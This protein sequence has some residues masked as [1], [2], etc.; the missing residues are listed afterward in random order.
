MMTTAVEDLQQFLAERASGIGGSDV[1]S[2]FS[3]GY[4]C[5]RRLSYDKRQVP[6]DFPIW[7]N[8]PMELGK[9]LEPYVARKYEEITGR[10]VEI[11]GVLRHP[12][13]PELLVHVDRIVTA[14]ERTDPG[15]MEIKAVG[16][17]MFA[18]IK[19]EGIL[20]DYTLQLNHGMLVA[21]LKWGCFAVMN[22]D[23][24]IS[25]PEDLLRWDVERDDEICA[26]ILEEGPLFWRNLHQDLHEEAFDEE[27]LDPGDSRC[28]RCPWRLQCQGAALMES[29][30]DDEISEDESLRPLIDEYLERKALSDEA[31]DLLEEIK[32]VIRT[33]MG[34]RGA[35]LSAGAK[36]YFRPQTT[37]RWD[38]KELSAAYSRAT[39][40]VDYDGRFIPAP[41]GKI[42]ERF[43]KGSV[44]RPLRIYPPKER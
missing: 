40:T 30:S 22:R 8:G 44:S 33:A 12:E 21:G 19:R 7:E 41:T 10:R 24:G 3:V 37:M 23:A 43:K 18:K 31:E 20:D 1:A 15:V 4:G 27:R 9:L 42:A 29:A 34:D 32:E 6:P 13:H 11:R 5:R 38:D 25:R 14:L 35:V 26:Q 2:L 28:Q 39:G 36:I 16:R 17:G